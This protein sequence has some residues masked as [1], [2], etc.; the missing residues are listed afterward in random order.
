MKIVR[1]RKYDG[2]WI[3]WY[4]DGS[5]KTFVD[6]L[7][8]DAVADFIDWCSEKGS[9]KQVGQAVEYTADPNFNTL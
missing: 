7:V 8:P 1:V 6:W 3:V 4:A 2:Y 9:I 5:R